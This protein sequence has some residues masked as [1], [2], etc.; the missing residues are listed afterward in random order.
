[1][2]PFAFFHVLDPEQRLALL[3]LAML[4]SKALDPHKDIRALDEHTYSLHIVESNAMRP[5]SASKMSVAPG[6]QSNV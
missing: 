3:P 2:E 4:N 1:M 5:Q 6:V